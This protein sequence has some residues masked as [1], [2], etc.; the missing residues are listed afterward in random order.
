MIVGPTADHR[1]IRRWAERHD[2]VPA[3]IRLYKFDSQPS[4]LHFL[5]GP[6]KGGTAELRPISWEDFFA[7]FDLMG[8]AMV[9][10][11]TPFFEILQ[12]EGEQTSSGRPGLA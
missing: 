5:F 10:D 6:A 12:V 1:E 2:A 9:F 11:E 8:L 4:V 3:E 7:R